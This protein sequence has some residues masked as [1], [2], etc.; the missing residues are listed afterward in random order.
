M[1]CWIRYRIKGKS[2][3]EPK[4]EFDSRDEMMRWFKDSDVHYETTSNP[5]DDE[6]QDKAKR[7][8]K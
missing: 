3:H 6:K 5:K 7:R 4:K 2:E 1:S 8:R